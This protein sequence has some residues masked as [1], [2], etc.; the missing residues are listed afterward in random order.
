MTRP[1]PADE[2]GALLVPTEAWHD[3]GPGHLALHRGEEAVGHLDPDL[4]AALAGGTHRRPSLLGYGDPGD[5][6]VKELGVAGRDEREDPK[7]DR[8]RHPARAEPTAS[9]GEHRLDLLDRIE[10]LGHHQVRP[11]FELALEP[12]PF[13]RRVGGG[14]VER[15]GFRGVFDSEQFFKFRE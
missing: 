4:R 1:N 8:D 12:I 10:R 15:D 9:L 6:V 3:V 14:R 7:Q 11:G 13:G 2:L 5:L